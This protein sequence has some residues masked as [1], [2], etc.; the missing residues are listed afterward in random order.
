MAEVGDGDLADRSGVVGEGDALVQ[1]LGGAVGA[2]DAF[3]FDAAPRGG[4][5]CLEF[6][7]QAG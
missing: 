5:C 4:R 7:E 1:D 2:V 3:E 6:C